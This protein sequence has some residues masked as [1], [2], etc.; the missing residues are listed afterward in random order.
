MADS[1]TRPSAKRLNREEKKARTRSALLDAAARVF[2]RNGYHRTSVDEVAAEAGYSKG[3][4]YSNFG[5]KEDLFLALFS[6]YVG[7]NLAL[8]DELISTDR[9]LDEQARESARLY[10]TAADERREWR[11]LLMEFWVAA[12]R[13]SDLRR[14]LAA[15]YAGLREDL[16]KV[17]KRRADDLGLRMRFPERVAA[18]ALALNE[19]YMIQHI[20]DPDEITRET[21]GDL[22]SLFF[23]ALSALSARED[24]DTRPLLQQE[25]SAHATGS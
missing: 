1:G 16:A 9:P 5:S 14:K 24:G 23:R 19:G 11:I 18:A 17:L 4:V 10:A 15:H 25:G 2:P 22:L 7:K 20:V 12:T 6:E 13:D 3:A 8:A 21:Y